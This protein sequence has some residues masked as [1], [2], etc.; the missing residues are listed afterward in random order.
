MGFDGFAFGAFPLDFHL[1][2][3]RFRRVGR[4]QAGDCCQTTEN[5]VAGLGSRAARILL[6]FFSS[7]FSTTWALIRPCLPSKTPNQCLSVCLGARKIDTRDRSWVCDYLVFATILRD[8]KAVSQRRRRLPLDDKHDR[9]FGKTEFI[10]LFGLIVPQR[11]H[12]G[13]LAR[14]W[15]RVDW[16]W[17][18]LALKRTS[19]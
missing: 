1:R 10:W 16:L 9:V 18:C 11:P 7:A 3:K 6:T 14:L 13:G 4:W 8:Q 2:R 12:S 17:L 5:K 19:C 15:K